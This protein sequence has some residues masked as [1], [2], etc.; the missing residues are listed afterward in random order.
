MIYDGVGR[1]G[2]VN[3]Y[4]SLRLRLLLRLGFG[5]NVEEL[6]NNFKRESLGLGHLEIYEDQRQ[7]ADEGIEA[8]DTRE[9]DGLKHHREGVGDGDVAQPEGEGAYGDAESPNTRG[10][11]L[12]T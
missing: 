11:D 8:K 4:I 9:A 12:G 10:E 5:A 2:M 7:A 6:N 3:I 1:N